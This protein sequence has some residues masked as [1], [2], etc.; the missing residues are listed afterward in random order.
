M[1]KNNPKR[2]VS[3]TS[4][5]VPTQ[6]RRNYISSG[7]KGGGG[8]PPDDS[9]KMAVGTG[10]EKNKEPLPCP[11]KLSKTSRKRASEAQQGIHEKN[12]ALGDLKRLQ[13]LDDQK[14]TPGH[15]ENP[16]VKWIFTRKTGEPVSLNAKSLTNFDDVGKNAV[17]SSAVWGSFPVLP[18]LLGAF[19]RMLPWEQ[20]EEILGLGIFTA[21]FKLCWSSNKSFK[22]KVDAIDSVLIPVNHVR[23][24]F[25]AYIKTIKANE[26]GFY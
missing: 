17:K 23:L 19:F 2:T 16:G 13:K 14:D 22:D 21:I 7:R 26:S 10:E 18:K 25:M 20:V 9:K 8:D 5:N 24:R 12:Q 3:S 1:T 11:D 15:S 6:P 4:G